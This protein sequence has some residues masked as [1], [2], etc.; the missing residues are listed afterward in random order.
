MA[1]LGRVSETYVVF[2]RNIARAR[3]LL[4]FQDLLDLL[5]YRGHDIIDALDRDAHSGNGCLEDEER[6]RT[7]ISNLLQNIDSIHTGTD[8]R[9]DQPL[10]Y[11][12]VVFAVTA[13]ESYLKNTLVE[14]MAGTRKHRKKINRYYR[15]SVDF[16]DITSYNINKYVIQKILGIRTFTFFRM[17]KVN[18]AFSQVLE[19]DR[20]YSIFDSGRQRTRLANFCELRHLIVHKG[21]I[22]DSIF[23]EKTGSD[24]KPGE[25]YPVTKKYLLDSM[26][27][28]GKVVDNI[29]RERWK[30]AGPRQ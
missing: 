12:A 14:L 2:Q 17:K 23:Y 5:L 16:S 29:E 25:Q 13:F 20:G 3:A 15:K 26:D 19:K 9:L 4:E 24:V 8:L 1:E 7:D 10:R 22:V 6:L 30:L 21:G 11:D 28:L 18:E 27:S